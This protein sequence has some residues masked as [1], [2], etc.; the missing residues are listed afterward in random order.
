MAKRDIHVIPAPTGGWNVRKAG[1]ERASKNFDQKTAAV[2][3]GRRVSKAERSELVIHRRDGTVQQ[4]D[5]YGKDP[6]PPKDK[7]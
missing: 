3:Y 4:K 6:V 5:S 7:R 1:A 2:D